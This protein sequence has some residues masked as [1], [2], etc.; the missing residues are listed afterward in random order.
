[1]NLRSILIRML[2]GI[3]PSQHNQSIEDSASRLAASVEAMR[4]TSKAFEDYRSHHARTCAELRSAA[5][6]YK[7]ESLRWQ[8][9][10]CRRYA[11][12][13]AAMG[14]AWRGESVLVA[15]EAAEA[16]PN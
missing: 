16:M 13:K 12:L 4:V 8:G 6:H 2:G 15:I 14:A 1:M 10:A 5:D 7:F 11:S 9:I 3:T